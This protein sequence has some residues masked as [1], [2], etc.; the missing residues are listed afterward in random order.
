MASQT[1]DFPFTI[2]DV[3]SLLRLKVRRRQAA[4]VYTDCPFCGDK[5]G[6]MNINYEKNVFRCNYCDE[7]GGM[8]ALYAKVYGISNSDA[9]REICDALQTGSHAPEYQIKTV[10]LP[11]SVQNSDLADI[12]KIHQTLSLLLSMLTLTEPHRKNLLDRGLTNEQ[13]ERLGYKSTPPPYLCQSLTERLIKQG[14]TVQGVPGFYMNDSGKWTA[15]FYKRTAGILIPARGIDGLVRGAQIR[16]DVPI[17]DENEDEDKEGTKYLWLSS[18]NKHMGVT[19]GSPVH[20]VG[21]PFARVIYVTEGFL[22]AD[23]AHCLMNRSFAAV[24]GANN[25]SQLDPVFSILARSG[26]KMIVEAHD[27]DKYRNEMI[28]KGASKIYLMAHS[29]GMETRR[30]TWNPNYKGVDNW[31]LALKKQKEAKIKEGCK[32]NFKQKFIS[33][34]CDID[35]IDECFEEWRITNGNP[36]DRDK[37]HGPQ[38][39]LGLTDQEMEAYGRSTYATGKEEL[40]QL[41]LAQQIRQRFRIYQLEFTSDSQTKPFAFQGIKA[42]HKAGYEQPPA[43][44]Y[45][46]VHDAELLC[47]A[48]AVDAEILGL[49]F[50]RYSDEL[51]D[52]YPGRSISPSDVIELYDNEKRQYFYRDTED[53]I[54]VKF[55]PVLALPMKARA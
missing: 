54:T 2:A 17:K 21:D 16:L 39:Y 30:L 24:A 51:P 15:K 12:H 43:S 14:C 3:A 33:G 5:R 38:Q 46:L 29:Y 13:I 18:S 23:V 42:L 27:M 1:R 6:K 25:L 11:P 37:E 41:L 7:R 20:F 36:L 48:A 44:E 9:Y 32:L 19:S 4:S 34:L 31:Q 49:I 47:S 26:T 35:H 55:S 8:V 53:F 50:S 45:R 40:K 22:K 28:E 10:E 52:D